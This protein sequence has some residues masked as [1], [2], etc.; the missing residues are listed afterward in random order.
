MSLLASS[1]LITKAA[2]K[3]SLEALNAVSTAPARCKKKPTEI[4]EKCRHIS[5]LRRQDAQAA[6]YWEN[7]LSE[8]RDKD[9]WP[10]RS[11]R[12]AEIQR[13]VDG[14]EP[15]RIFHTDSVAEVKLADQNAR[16]QNASNQPSNLP[17]Y[18]GHSIQ[19]ENAQRRQRPPPDLSQHNI[20]AIHSKDNSAALKDLHSLHPRNKEKD[21]HELADKLSKN[22]ADITTS[23][24]EKAYLDD[25]ISYQNFYKE[26]RRQKKME[27]TALHTNREKLD[28]NTLIG[29]IN[30]ATKKVFHQ[31]NHLLK[32]A[33]LTAI[34]RD[35]KS[36]TAALH[37]TL[38]TEISS[39]DVK[40]IGA[41]LA[42]KQRTVPTAEVNLTIEIKLKLVLKQQPEEIASSPPRPAISP[43]SPPPQ[44]SHETRRNQQL[45]EQYTKRAESQTGTRA[46]EQ[47]LLKRWKCQ[48]P[49]C[50]N[51]P[52]FCF[53]DFGS[54]EHYIIDTVTQQQ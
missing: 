19:F 39:E 54:K 31:D 2:D 45:M 17:E 22:T 30:T 43:I 10:Q 13:Y 5:A 51:G 24:V 3:A 21:R 1:I 8:L 15:K 7:R 11:T 20:Q 53:E 27:Y 26:R 32:E 9:S 48:K 36:H 33:N 37:H 40:K 14:K 4:Y 23:N 49:N 16:P 12:M 28:L 25:G 47:Q 42:D 38:D 41:L 50:V 29:V 46:F 52:N 6:A 34:I 35:S 18:G 44:H